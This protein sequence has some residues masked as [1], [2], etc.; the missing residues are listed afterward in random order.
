MKISSDM[1]GKK[2]YAG[3]TKKYKSGYELWTKKKM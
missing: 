3:H 2:I 1:F